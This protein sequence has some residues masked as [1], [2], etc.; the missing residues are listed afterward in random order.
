M[1]VE[2][3]EVNVR[4]FKQQGRDRFEGVDAWKDEY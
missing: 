4:I 2:I 3:V 1:R